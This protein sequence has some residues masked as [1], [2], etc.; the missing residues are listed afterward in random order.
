MKIESSE[1]YWSSEFNPHPQPFPIEWGRVTL[2]QSR[3]DYQTG[4][5]IYPISK[6]IW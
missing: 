4:K 1:C 6:N 5:F 3:R 2:Q